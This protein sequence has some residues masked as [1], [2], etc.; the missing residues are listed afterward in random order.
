MSISENKTFTTSKD[1]LVYLSAAGHECCDLNKSS[2]G[3]NTIYVIP[4]NSKIKYIGIKT[5]EGKRD[6]ELWQ[7]EDRQFITSLNCFAKM[8]E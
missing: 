4:K 8:F 6:Y 1:L 2:W 3:P 7:Y 5:I